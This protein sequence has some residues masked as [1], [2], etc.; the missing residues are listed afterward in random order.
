MSSSQD[1]EHL[2][3]L[4]TFHYVVGGIGVLFACMPLLHLGFGIAFL[5]GAIPEANDGSGPPEWFGLLFVLIGGMFFI[6]GQ[7]IA[8][9][10]IYSG[11]QLKN[12]RKY[13]F[14]FIV[15][16]VMCFFIPFGT[17][18]GIFTIV[19]LSRESVKQLYDRTF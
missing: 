11:K 4:A 1:Q 7:A 14:S 19:V 5:A 12:R 2:N 18:L 10:I 3:L 16:C 8:W 15:A 6:I 13:M 17:V 9:G